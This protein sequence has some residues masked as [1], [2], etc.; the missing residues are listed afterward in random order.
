MIQVVVPEAVKARV[1]QNMYPNG[2]PEGLNI[3]FWDFATRDPVNAGDLD[4][5]LSFPHPRDGTKVAEAL[6]SV[7]HAGVP[8]DSFHLVDAIGR[9]IGSTFAVRQ[10]RL[11]QNL[12][13]TVHLR[14][15]VPKPSLAPRGQSD[16]E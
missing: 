2:S 10:R 16:E 4:P 13:G 6:L 14:H 3:D 9:L 1:A 11:I 7:E 15:R 12:G 5:S 8:E